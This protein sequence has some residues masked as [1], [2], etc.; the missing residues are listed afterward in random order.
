MYIYEEICF[1]ELASMT[2]EAVKSQYLQ[3]G[4]VSC[5]TKKTGTKFLF[6]AKDL[7]PRE[8]DVVVSVQGPAGLKL[9]KS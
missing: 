7:K 8:V 1:K 5:R 6:W 3:G 2:I 9:R 4:S